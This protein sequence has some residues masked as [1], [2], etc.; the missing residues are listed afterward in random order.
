MYVYDVVVDRATFGGIKKIDG[1]FVGTPRFR[2]IRTRN[3]IIARR[4]HIVRTVSFFSV[5][6]REFVFALGEQNDGM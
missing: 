4:N 1:I 5:L 3:I 2:N 6:M